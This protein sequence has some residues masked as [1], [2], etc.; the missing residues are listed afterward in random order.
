MATLD[1]QQR[2][3]AIAAQASLWPHV[4]D[5]VPGMNNLTILFD[6]LAADADDLTS[7]LLHAWSSANSAKTKK[8]TGRQIEI[9]IKYGG[10]NGPDLAAV[11]A[12][13]GLTVQEV[14]QRHTAAEYIVYFLGFQPGFA[15]LGG[16]DP[17][18]ATPRRSE[19]RLLVPAGSVGIG[20]SQTAIY[21][22]AS[23]GGWQLIGHTAIRLFDPDANPPTLLQPG[24]RV[25]FVAT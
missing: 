7:K 11:A 3:W 19:P 6:P 14:V 8:Q 5:V 17:T 24:D 21:P 10:V 18:L 22:A 12:H 13:T 23:P 20:G 2:L 25:Q 4:R 9:P 1:C 15:Y 16:L